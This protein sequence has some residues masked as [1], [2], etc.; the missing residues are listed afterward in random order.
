MITIIRW[1][2]AQSLAVELFLV[3]ANK[4]ETDIIFRDEWAPRMCANTRASIVIKC[5][6]SR[7]RVGRKARAASPRPCCASIS[8]RPVL[9]P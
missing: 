6:S 9:T 2:L 4:T 7:L 5:W 1:I 8:H 3:F